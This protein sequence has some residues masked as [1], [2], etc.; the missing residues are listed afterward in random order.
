[1]SGFEIGLLV[2]AVAAAA[3]CRVVGRAEPPQPGRDWI[4]PLVFVASL[5]FQVIRHQLTDAAW[6]PGGT[7]WDQWFQS[8]LAFFG[9]APYPPNRWPLYGALVAALHVVTPGAL[10][11]KAQ[12]VS[13][14]A[15]A[16]ALAGLFRLSRPLVGLPGALAVA[17]LAGTLPMTLELGDWSNAYPLWGAC[18]VWAV[19]AM[20]EGARTRKL[21]WWVAA[22]LC[23][24]LQMAAMEKGL[25]PGLLLGALLVA[26]LVWSG[27]RRLVNAAGAAAP[28]VVLALCYVLFPHPLMTL[29]AA[30]LSDA[31]T[32]CI[33]RGPTVAGQFPDPPAT[34]HPFFDPKVPVPDRYT[35]GGYV[36]G[37]SMGPLASLRALKVVG[38]LTSTE[39]KLA[40][41]RKSLSMLRAT[42]PTVGLALLLC[43][44]LAPALGLWL[45]R[46]R[47]RRV[48]P[49]WL[50]LG[51]IVA[52]NYPALMSAP[53]PRFL[54]PAFSVVAVFVITPVVIWSRAWASTWRW[55][56][57]AACLV[58]LL[59]GSPWWGGDTVRA[60]LLK[61]EVPGHR[62]M[63]LRHE[64]AKTLP[65]VPL[66][67]MVPTRF[68]VLLLDGREGWQYP[69]DP[70]FHRR[71]RKVDPRRH[72]LVMVPPGGQP[73]KLP[74]GFEHCHMQPTYHDVRGGRA[75]LG[76]YPLEPPGAAAVLL[77]PKK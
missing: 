19:T 1:M 53:D 28:M 36:F 64:V 68:G 7:D 77:G 46:R 55:A 76:R 20:V 33:M 58:A 8:A 59:P 34:A 5:V 69:E 3:L 18:M 66:E 23:L 70:R 73:V 31:D 71:D 72:V 48:L 41:H 67:V 75:E 54:L 29:E 10:F 56:A 32:Y 39:Q 60:A 52:A 12:L 63:S 25:G 2:L 22:G 17:A 45:E 62:A 13:H 4:T 65:D 38:A 6:I 16:A 26:L 24:G 49:G 11:I 44:A 40:V 15:T 14:V 9:Q 27:G 30:A 51:A 37:R 50:G 35:T 43:M 74:P 57:A 42:F 47:W 61:M 21:G